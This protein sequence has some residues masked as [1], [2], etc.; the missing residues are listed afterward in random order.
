MIRRAA[1]GRAHRPRE[2]Q[3]G[4]GELLAL[5]SLAKETK[6]AAHQFLLHSTAAVGLHAAM[7]GQHQ[8]MSAMRSR[9]CASCAMCPWRRLSC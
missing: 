9:L 6:C 5:P 4:L 7:S 8:G 1:A 2:R 3:P